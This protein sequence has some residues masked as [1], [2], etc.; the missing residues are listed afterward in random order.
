MNKNEFIENVTQNTMNVLQQRG[1]NDK[2]CEEISKIITFCVRTGY[3]R[4]Y[5]DYGRKLLDVYAKLMGENTI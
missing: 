5:A 1:L 3:E 2:A 4:G